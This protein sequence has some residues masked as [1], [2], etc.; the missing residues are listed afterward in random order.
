MLTPL[1]LPSDCGAHRT[2]RRRAPRAPAGGPAPLERAAGQ[3]AWVTAHAAP[4]SRGGRSSRPMGGFLRPARLL[5][6]PP[7]DSSHLCEWRQLG[8]LCKA[9]GAAASWGARHGGRGPHSRADGSGG[10]RLLRSSGPAPPPQPDETHTL[11][12]PPPPLSRRRPRRAGDALTASRWSPAE[13]SAAHN[14]PRTAI[15]LAP[16]PPGQPSAGRM[17]IRGMGVGWGRGAGRPRARPALLFAARLTSSCWMPWPNPHTGGVPLVK[18][19][20][21]PLLPPPPRSPPSP[22]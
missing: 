3:C 14:A 18:Y 19:T 21:R 2:A 11:L 9:R 8:C 12:N 5:S 10:W 6:A 16:S 20:K 17:L 4:G 13:A 15:P 22:L 7:R 1:W